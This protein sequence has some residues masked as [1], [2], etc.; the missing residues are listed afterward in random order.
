MRDIKAEILSIVS[1]GAEAFSIKLKVDWNSYIPGQFAM[2]SIPNVFLR[3]PFSVA[4]FSDGICEIIFKIVGTGT[5]ALSSMKS[6]ET[7]SILGPC[8]NGFNIS[9]IEHDG[10][11]IAVCVAGGYGIAPIYGLSEILCNSGVEVH[12]FYGAVSK[13]DLLL[14]DKLKAVG[15]GLNVATEDG[16][17]GFKGL[18]TELLNKELSSTS[19]SNVFACGPDGLLKALGEIDALRSVN[20][21]VSLESHMACGMGVCLGC[22]RRMK[23]GSFAHICKDGPVFDLNDV[24]F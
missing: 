10:K 2:L 6:G 19:P 22:A 20:V 11:D 15:A 13:F 18:V 7:I 24:L 9:N 3:R 4:Q 17:I 16:S 21:Q 5:R 23:D 14:L 8:G 12:V 1:V